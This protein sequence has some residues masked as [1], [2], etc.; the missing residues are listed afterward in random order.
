MKILRIFLVVYIL[1]CLLM[2]VLLLFGSEIFAALG[3]DIPWD[4]IVTEASWKLRDM[5]VSAAA[6]LKTAA[7]NT[8]AWLS[9]VMGAASDGLSAWVQ[10]QR[11]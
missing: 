5:A 7:V 6:A 3:W 8:A 2:L 9:N 1:V 10:T 4:E 11:G